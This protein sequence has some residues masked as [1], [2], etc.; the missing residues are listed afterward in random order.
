MVLGLGRLR[1][2]DTVDR[3]KFVYRYVRINDD[4]TRA[5]FG[6]NVVSTSEQ[7]TCTITQIKS[8]FE[9]RSTY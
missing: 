7:L 3:V 5:G 1:T 9:I 4:L 6:S 2:P 8:L